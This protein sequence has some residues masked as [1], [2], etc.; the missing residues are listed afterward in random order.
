MLEVWLSSAPM[1]VHLVRLVSWYPAVS[2][3]AAVL[4]FHWLE[5]QYRPLG[6]VLLLMISSFCELLLT[7]KAIAKVEVSLGS[8]LA[9]AFGQLLGILALVAAT[10]LIEALSER[11]GGNQN[12]FRSR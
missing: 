5:E 3:G 7:S 9:L 1:R 2:L 11:V 10:R 6:I 12:N 8:L 4:L